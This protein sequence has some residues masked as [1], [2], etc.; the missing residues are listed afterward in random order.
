MGILIQTKKKK[1]ENRNK[2][3]TYTDEWIALQ[4][5]KTFSVQEMSS[6]KTYLKNHE[7]ILR[8]DYDI[9]NLINTQIGPQLS[10]IIAVVK[11]PEH[12]VKN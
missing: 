5:S 9:Q 1:V 8:Q 2:R 6:C 3:T 10:H 12:L 7:A 4:V 11:I